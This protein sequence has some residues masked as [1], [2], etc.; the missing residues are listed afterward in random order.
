M[1]LLAGQSVY[2]MP[3]KASF[4]ICTLHFNLDSAILHRV[5]KPLAQHV[6]SNDGGY[7]VVKRIFRQLRLQIMQGP[8]CMTMS[9]SR[10]GG[11]KQV[12]EAEV[13][14]LT[15]GR[16]CL[17]GISAVQHTTPCAYLAQHSLLLWPAIKRHFHCLPLQFAAWN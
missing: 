12:E 17:R 1:K 15:S 11:Q 8:G 4:R 2:L 16:A 13:I 7:I 3:Y 5:F 10:V 6:T 9:L 14:P